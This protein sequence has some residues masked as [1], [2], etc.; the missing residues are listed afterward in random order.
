M[1]AVQIA[2]ADNY[3]QR[4]NGCHGSLKK[5]NKMQYICIVIYNYIYIYITYF[6]LNSV[7]KQLNRTYENIFT[8]YLNPSMQLKQLKYFHLI[9]I[10]S[11]SGIN[12][13]LFL[14][15]YVTIHIPVDRC[16]VCISLIRRLWSKYK[17]STVF[18]HIYN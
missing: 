4:I 6:Y 12:P 9:V 14:Y 2:H 5:G 10:F 1:E 3:L 16:R 17:I 8:N 11:V 18:V 13:H 15:R 7:W